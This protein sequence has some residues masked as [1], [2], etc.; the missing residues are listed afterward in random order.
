MQG[1]IGAITAIAGFFGIIG[2][3][4]AV[5]F[6]GITAIVM[7]ILNTFGVINIA[8][9]AGPFTAGAVSTGIWMFVLGLLM[10]LLSYL[11]TAIGAFL[12]QE[13]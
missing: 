8:W 13:A 9:F 5:K 6:S 2:S 10:L 7:I 3:A 1:I 12:V 4:V 11:V